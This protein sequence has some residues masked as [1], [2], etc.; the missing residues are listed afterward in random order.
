[1]TRT[2]FAGLAGLLC[3]WLLATFTAQANNPGKVAVWFYDKPTTIEK[4]TSHSS[5]PDSPTQRYYITSLAHDL[6]DSSYGIRIDGF[7]IVPTIADGSAEF[8]FCSYADNE[9][10]LHIGLTG[11]PN[12][13]TLVIDQKDHT[14]INSWVEGQTVALQSEAVLPFTLLFAEAWGSDHFAA[15]WSCTELGIDHAVIGSDNI[16][17]PDDTT[18]PTFV[19]AELD[20]ASDDTVRLVWHADDNQGIWEYDVVR[21][22]TVLTT[23]SGT[24]ETYDDTT[25]S[26]SSSYTFAIVARD[27]LNNSV[28]SDPIPTTTLDPAPVGSGVGLTGTYFDGEGFTEKTLVRV[29]ST[30]DF[31]W[32]SGSP[33][34]SM[35]DN[36]FTIRWEGTLI[37]QY[38]ETY[39]FETLSDD[40]VLLF[41]DDR[42]VISSWRDQSPAWRSGTVDLQAGVPVSIRLDY[43]EK[44][45]GAV[46]GLYWKSESTLKEVIPQSQLLPFGWAEGSDVQITTGNSSITSP[47]FIAG[48]MG[49]DAESVQITVDG[50]TAFDAALL[51]HTN[52]YGDNASAG[53]SAFGIALNAAAAT[54]VVASTATDSD[55]INIVWTPTDISST[56]EVTIRRLD[57]L[58]LSCSGTGTTLEIDADGDGTYELSGA[59]GTSFPAA[60]GTAGSFTAAA[61]IDGAAAGS[62]TV[63]VVDTEV[64]PA[65]G[66]IQGK[67]RLREI[68]VTPVA[69]ADSIEWGSATTGIT[70]IGGVATTTTGSEVTLIASLTGTGKVFSRLGENGPIIRFYDTHAFD[71]KFIDMRRNPVFVSYPDGSRLVANS[72]EMDPYFP[73]HE[74]KMRVITSTPLFENG[75]KEFWAPS[76]DF[77]KNKQYVLYLLTEEE[78]NGCHVEGDVREVE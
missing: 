6:S 66:C 40:G 8:Q 72:I 76:S 39:T 24:V 29:D 23:L 26:P 42:L 28:T 16:A 77:D 61:K 14:G 3:F 52:F 36:T 73:G 5:Y 17:G 2:R 47:A 49:A 75:T 44:Y 59:V 35:D 15:G 43:Y 78:V 64:V 41:I 62:L 34:P 21:D 51:D 1:M 53:G 12:D 25:V 74:I 69:A 46:C 54:E 67:D 71:V 55:T 68:A 58:L 22:G 11:D 45:G 27:A 56:T 32:G 63:H 30:V 38:S 18:A 50:G 48:R 9:I 65:I 4:L 70:D 13:M 60:Y 19:T 20:Q 57:S 37:P 33:D 31:D 10:E 7:I